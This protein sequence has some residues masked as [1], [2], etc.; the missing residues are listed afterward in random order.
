MSNILVIADLKQEQTL[1]IERALTIAKQRSL[2]LHVVYFCYESLRYVSG[3]EDE[4][5]ANVLTR[6]DEHA[7]QQLANID[8][9][10]VSY[11]YEV[12]WEKYIPNWVEEYTQAND[13]K[14]VVKT[15]HRTERLLYT[16]LDWQLMRECSAPVMIAAPE[17]WRKTPNVLAA[18]DLG[19]KTDSKQAL[20]KLV[21]EKAR[22]LADCQEA[23]LFV[24]YTIRSSKLLRD[25]GFQY[26]DELEI[27]AERNLKDKVAEI[28][29]IY[30]VPEKNIILKAGEA[31]KVIPSQAA[32]NKAGIVVMGTVGRRG[33]KGKLMG[34]TAEKVLKLLKCDVVAIKPEQ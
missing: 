20:N 11:S 15:G 8:F 34:N 31:E 12:C 10:G 14:L 13:V 5:K 27:A 7:Q 3:Q 18:I 17:T 26:L 33:V 2:P 16:P 19:T 25:M 30:G 22:A 28:S 9:D 4:V 32:A 6:L 24:C 1:A 21:L 29:S 23:E